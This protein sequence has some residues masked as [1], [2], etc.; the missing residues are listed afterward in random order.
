M[1]NDYF[2]KNIPRIDD[3]FV[4][5][6]NSINKEIGEWDRQPCHEYVMVNKLMKTGK[7]NM[8]DLERKSFEDLL[9]LYNTLKK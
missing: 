9:V 7:Y 5:K 4:R 1:A 2:Y 8:Y 3:N 6:I